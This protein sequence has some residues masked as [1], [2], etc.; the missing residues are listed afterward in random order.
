[1]CHYLDNNNIAVIVN[2]LFTS[3]FSWENIASLPHHAP[4][5]NGIDP[6]EVEDIQE[7]H[8]QINWATPFVLEITER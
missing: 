7:Q 6:L 5:E 1:M 3:V 2:E 4:P 8:Q